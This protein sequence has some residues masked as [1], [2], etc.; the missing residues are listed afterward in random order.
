M[1]SYDA[2]RAHAL[3]VI[4]DDEISLSLISLQLKCEGYEVIQTLGGASAL[5]ILASLTPDAHPAAVLADLHMPGLSGPALAAELRRA[6]PLAKLLAMSATPDAAEG[7]DGFLKKPLDPAALCT[8]LN[9]YI[10]ASVSLTT[11]DENRP[12]LDEAVFQ[13]MSRMMPP[14]AL[15]EVY[16]ACLKDA[17]ARE[18]EMRAAAAANDLPSVRRI[19]HTVKGSAAM[20]G[21]KKLAASAAE[22][23]LGDYKPEQVFQLIGN[24]LSY[25]DELHRI[26]V[27]KLP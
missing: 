13:K 8:L 17:R 4:D 12:A 6:V 10:P 14:T 18:Q 11:G 5:E 20:V 26:L 15:R 3:M 16:E 24:L 27:A 1:F 19:A 22:L 7:Y 23:E 21:A 2:T 9:G 25:C